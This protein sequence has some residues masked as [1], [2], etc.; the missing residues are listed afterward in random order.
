V[1]PLAL[2][3]LGAIIRWLV[4]LTA[5]YLVGH[6]VLTDTQAQ[7]AAA[8]VTEHVF[9]AVCTVAPLVWSIY[10]KKLAALKLA[11]AQSQEQKV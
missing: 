11:A 3:I 1:T 8:H 9:M 10:Q 7:Y 6:H 2:Q 5:G 4:G